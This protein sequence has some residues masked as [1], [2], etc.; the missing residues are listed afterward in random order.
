MGWH[1]G[2]MNEKFDGLSF[3]CHL[4]A[5]AI[6]IPFGWWLKENLGI[7]EFLRSLF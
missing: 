5:A 3:L 7:A 1:G 2:R 4:V 6:L